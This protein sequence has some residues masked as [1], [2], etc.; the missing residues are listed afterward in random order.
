MISK[1]TITRYLYKYRVDSVFSEKIFTEQ[2]LWFSHPDEFNDPF[3][4]WANIQSFDK[5]RL[6]AILI[7]RNYEENKI[8]RLKQGINNYT[9]S[10]FKRHIDSVMNQIGVCCFSMTSKSILMWSHYAHYHQGFCLVFD[11]LNDPDFFTVARPVN[12]IDTMPEFYFPLDIDEIVERVILPK[13]TEWEYEQEI[14]IIKLQSDIESNGNQVFKFNPN[15]LRKIIFGCKAHKTTI[16]KYKDLCKKNGFKHVIF[17]QMQQK[18]D[19]SFEL[20][21]RSI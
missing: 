18:K 1:D 5:K 10:D 13:S 16:Q 2:T 15:A 4:C 14:R 21:E 3:D 7:Q 8:R 17:S 11:V 9:E 6:T 12:Y 19:G 20:K